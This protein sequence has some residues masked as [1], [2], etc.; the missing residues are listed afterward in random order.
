MGN[1]ST[2]LPGWSVT[3]IF[4]PNRGFAAFL[5]DVKDS[6]QPNVLLSHFNFGVNRPKLM[7]WIMSTIE[8]LL[9]ILKTICRI[10]C[11]YAC[12]NEMPFE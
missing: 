12:A 9:N 11:L 10:L 6:G 3:F 2:S 8:H 5:N 7:D 1:P 4:C